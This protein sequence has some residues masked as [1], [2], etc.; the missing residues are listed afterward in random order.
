MA[1][2]NRKVAHE[3]HAG[4]QPTMWPK[5]AVAAVFM[6]AVR[7]LV[8][9]QAAPEIAVREQVD[10]QNY[11]YQEPN[12]NLR[13]SRTDEQRF[14]SQ[15]RAVLNGTA[16]IAEP[17]ARSQ[18][19]GFYLSYLYPM[20]TT[21][22][23]LRTIGKE[24]QD[25]LRDLATSKNPEAHR[26]VI[27]F[28]LPAMTKI[29]QD[30]AYRPAARYNAMLIIS[31]L[32]DVEPNNIGTTQ[33][34][35][36][37]TKAALPTIFQQFQKADRD[38]IKIAALLGLGRHLEWDNYK[39][40][41][42][43]PAGRAAIIKELVALAEAKEAPTGR[44]PSVHLW[45]RRRAVEALS[46]ACLTKADADITAA[47]ERLL[48]DE[49]EPTTLRLAVATAF[50]KMSLQAPA[51]LDPVVTAKELGYLALK[52]TDAEVTRA[53]A[54]RKAE[55]EHEARL[56]GNYQGD[57]SYS[58][59]PGGMPGAPGGRSG[60]PGGEGGP[61]VVRRSTGMPGGGSLDGAYG[62]GMP[63]G[64][65]GMLDP[66][67]QDPK[68]FE[69]EYLRRRLR[70]NLYA[71]QLG[72]LG[73]EDH[74]RPKPTPTGKS[75][76]TPP[77]PP[78][79]PTGTGE[80][81]DPRGMFAI[82]KTEPEKNQVNEVYYAVRDLA[83]AIESAGTTAEFHQLLK[84][85]KN[86]LK[87]LELVVGRRVPPPGAPTGTEDEPA[88]GPAGKAGP[89]GPAGKGKAIPAKGKPGAPAKSANRQPPQPQPN[90]FARP[91]VG[92]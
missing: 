76:P 54:H 19:R 50:G 2:V 51:K 38:E 78:T 63:G 75:P 5:I 26:E 4:R 13:K 74:T 72:L 15:A 70:Q 43:P 71:V 41:P 64:E 29:V 68:H 8:A 1:S 9:Q 57:V 90:V 14:R 44:E 89:K 22:E 77:T 17:A 80:K 21:E 53:D 79:L 3:T 86:K 25:L 59:G 81:K 87:S 82:A 35:P 56:A 73:T 18:F 6:L 85:V 33:T 48:R 10:A 84:D 23:G 65:M 91:G 24:R 37:P 45:M 27:E 28:T 46:L 34:L 42:M 83:E 60:M 12:V 66:S 49:A 11:K 67:M 58:S 62:G 36:E 40:A 31:S 16:S 32:N 7:I 69:V 20:M 55:L 47:M 92:R 61:M 88:G 30:P 39:Q 52:A